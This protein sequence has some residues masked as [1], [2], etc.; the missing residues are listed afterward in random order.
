LAIF[1][2]G[3]PAHRPPLNRIDQDTIELIYPD[4]NLQEISMGAIMLGDMFSEK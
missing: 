1:S 3:Y 2:V 4:D